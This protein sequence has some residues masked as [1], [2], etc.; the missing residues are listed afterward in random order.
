[1]QEN[2]SQLAQLIQ[3]SLVD[4]HLDDMEYKLMSAMAE[5]LGVS[6]DQLDDLIVERP[7]EQKLPTSEFDRILQF[8]RLVLLA[9]VDATVNGEELEILRKCG[10]RLGLRPEAVETILREMHKHENG[11]LP[12]ALMM[13]IFQRYHN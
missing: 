5:L 9:N 8:H 11:M 4:G 12:T 13:E 3:L 1:M 2:L 6:Q 7:K 10:L